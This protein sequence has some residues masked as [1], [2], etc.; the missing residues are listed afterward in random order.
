LVWGFLELNQRLDFKQEIVVPL[1][2]LKSMSCVHELQNYP[3]HELQNY[4]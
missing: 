1:R 3:R 4:H 2:C